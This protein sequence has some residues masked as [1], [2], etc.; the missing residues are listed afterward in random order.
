MPSSLI[1][2]AELASIRDAVGRLLPHTCVISSLGEISDAQG[3]LTQAWTACG[4]VD[5]RIVANSGGIR[6]VGAQNANVG[7]YVLTVPSGTDI[8]VDD[9]A[10]IDGVT[11]RIVFVDDVKSWQAAVRCDC[12]LEVT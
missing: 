4:T 8:D 5:A 12:N 3:G 2:T 10:T 9:R 11:Y 7:A 1:G 6:A